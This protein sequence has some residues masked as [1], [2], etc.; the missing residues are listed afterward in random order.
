MMKTFLMISKS[1][2]DVLETAEQS[3]QAGLVLSQGEFRP[4]LRTLT[5]SSYVYLVLVN[6]DQVL[7]VSQDQ[8]LVKTALDLILS[9]RTCD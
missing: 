2:L 4:T 8:V 3:Q 6:K 7:L 5:S 1:S 9:D